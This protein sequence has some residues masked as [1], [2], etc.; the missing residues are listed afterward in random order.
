M[1]V[2]EGLVG[3][4][5]ARALDRNLE[6]ECRSR[7]KDQSMRP[8]PET[9]CAST[10]PSSIC[11]KIG[12]G[13]RVVVSRG[14]ISRVPGRI[15][16]EAGPQQWTTLHMRLLSSSC[17][18]QT[19][20][21]IWTSCAII[22]LEA[23]VSRLRIAIRIV[24]QAQRSLSDST[25][26]PRFDVDVRCTD[27]WDLADLSRVV[28]FRACLEQQLRLTATL[29]GEIIFPTDETHSNRLILF[30]E[31]KPYSARPCS[32]LLDR[33]PAKKTTSRTWWTW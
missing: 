23:S 7:L 21:E 3:R 4:V 15:L 18:G 5:F 8:A 9:H 16:L 14:E 32:R 24:L 11:W 28:A 1:C 30:E 10:H 31:V 12:P 17:V 2:C 6:T 20:P 25:K 22:N 29:T 33:V 27:V 13:L 26:F 19:S